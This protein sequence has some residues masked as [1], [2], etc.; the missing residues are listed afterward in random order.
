MLVVLSSPHA[1]PVPA[2]GPG[3]VPELPHHSQGENLVLGVSSGD[4]GW[5]LWGHWVLP[6]L[7]AGCWGP[8][9]VEINHISG[10]A[11]KGAQGSR[12]APLVAAVG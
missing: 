10:G 9:W 4:T 8:V 5:G 11:K 2:S 1:I 6:A 12:P 3:D 7:P